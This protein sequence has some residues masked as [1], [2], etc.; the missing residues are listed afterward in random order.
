MK[1]NLN[2]NSSKQSVLLKQ[3]RISLAIKK[4][5]QIS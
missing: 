4:L 5:E 1:N 3:L 2:S